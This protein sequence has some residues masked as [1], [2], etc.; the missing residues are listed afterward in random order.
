MEAAAASLI[1]ISLSRSSLVKLGDSSCSSSAF[2]PCPWPLRCPPCSISLRATRP[3]ACLL[4]ARPAPRSPSS[5]AAA[6]CSSAAC[7]PPS[8]HG[9]FPCALV[10]ACPS[11]V[12][13]RAPLQCQTTPISLSQFVSSLCSSAA[14]HSSLPLCSP[15]IPAPPL[16]LQFYGRAGR[17]GVHH[18][19]PELSL[20]SS[21]CFS[22]TSWR[23]ILRSSHGASLLASPLKFMASLS[24]ARPLRLLVVELPSRRR[25]SFSVR[26]AFVRA[27]S[28]SLFRMSAQFSLLPCCG[29]RVPA[30]SSPSSASTKNSGCSDPTST[31]SSVPAVVDCCHS[32]SHHAAACPLSCSRLILPFLLCLASVV[33]D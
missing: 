3:G 5:V 32:P 15:R 19:Q 8:S 10:R 9:A 13:G 33:F 24:I 27:C 17:P 29:R 30:R 11:G 12:H 14:P 21:W 4:L 2:P 1:S 18:A 20:H 28:S 31:K 7:L 6:V 16:H 25:R 22:P 26:S 23:W